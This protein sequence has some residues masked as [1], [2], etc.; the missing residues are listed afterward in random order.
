M[1]TK[2]KSLTKKPK[3]PGGFTVDPTLTSKY[4]DQPLFK[5]KVD[6][7][8]YILKTVRLPKFGQPD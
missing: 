7:A 4:N 1:K 2:K 5:D 3:L 6:R 8:N